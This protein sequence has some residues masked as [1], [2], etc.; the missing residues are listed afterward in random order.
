MTD[1]FI[2]F[3][4]QKISE[5]ASMLQQQLDK[6]T[7]ASDIIRNKHEEMK[8]IWLGQTASEYYKKLSSVETEITRIQEAY[9]ELSQELY[10]VSGVY[11][12]SETTTKQKAESLPIDGVFK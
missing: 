7:F 10:Q 12:T 4:P 9:A 1:Q 2:K 5:I 3:D 6:F 11:A 8:S